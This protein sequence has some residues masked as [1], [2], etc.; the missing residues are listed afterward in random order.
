MVL[1][2]ARRGRNAGGQF[3][4]CSNYPNCKG[5]VPFEAAGTATPSAD[6]PNVSS[7]AKADQ[8]YFVP[9]QWSD[10]LVRSG[11]ISEYFSVGSVPYI[12]LQG[13]DHLTP[14]EERSL[15]QSV[16]LY[17]RSLLGAKISK[18]ALVVSNI[19]Q[20]ILRRGVCPTT[21]PR[22][23]ESALQD[24]GL[25]SETED[26]ALKKVEYGRYWKSGSKRIPAGLIIEGGLARSQFVPDSSIA[27]AS[28]GV[29]DSP[30]EDK[31]FNEWLPGIS[32][33]DARHWV[34]PQASL[35]LI[36][37]AFGGGETGFGG[38]RVDFLF[39]HPNGEHFV[40]E[41]D[42]EEHRDSAESDAERDR[43]LTAAGIDVFR[44]PNA[45]VQSG[46]G[47][48]LSRIRKR[49]EEALE[50]D[51]VFDAE[52][53]R[54]AS[55]IWECSFG[56][57]LQVAIAW[58]LQKGILQTGGVW[59]VR[60]YEHSS[61]S[62]D[63]IREVC[64]LI[65][66][67]GEI[68]GLDVAPTWIQIESDRG[69]TVFEKISH[70]YEE[71][72]RL[73][74]D[75]QSSTLSVRLE[76]TSSPL[77]QVR[78]EA[79]QEVDL[80]IRPAYFP[81]GLASPEFYRASRVRANGKDLP[82]LRKPLQGFLRTIFRKYEFRE[83][84]F[85]AVSNALL[86]TDSVVLLP[87]GAGKSIIYQL[88]GLLLPGV[89]LVVD[90]LV[91][92]IEDQ[93]DGMKLYGISKAIGVNAYT[94]K[95]A[96]REKV[97][98][99][100]GRGEYLFIL[101]APERLQD[102]QFRVTLA[103][104]AQISVINLAV[105]DEA[106]CVSEWGH[107]FRPSYL[108]LGR[109]LREFCKD[110]EGIPPP[111]VALTGTASR[112][113]LRDLLADLQISTEDSGALIRPMSFDRSEISFDIR[114]SK[115]GAAMGILGG[116]MNSIPND[117]GFPVGEFY[118]PS[119]ALT[120]SGIVFTKHVNGTFGLSTVSQSI[121]SS[122]P[123]EVTLYSGSAP[124]GYVAND[125][126]EVKRQNA[127]D[128]KSNKIPILVATKAFGM[129]IDKPN[130]RYTIHY[131]MP[132]SLE[133]FYQEAGRAG[134]DRNPAK[135]YVIY[136]EFDQEVTDSLLDPSKDVEEIRQIF[137]NL[138]RGS[139]DDASNSLW[140][141][142]NS[143][144][145]IET[146]LRSAAK[147]LSR[148]LPADQAEI[149]QIP[150]SIE[151]DKSAAEKAIFRLLQCG[152]LS[153][154]EVDNGSRVFGLYLKR[155]DREAIVSSVL[156]Y[157]ASSQ[158]GRLKDIAN[159]LYAINVDDQSGYVLQV[160]RIFITF[161]YDV[162]ERSRRRSL[163]ESMHA[164]REV[165]EETFRR[166]LLDY[167]QE[168][169]GAEAIQDLIVK[170][171]MEYR[172]WIGFLEKMGNAVE[173]G[174]VRGVAIRFLESYPDHPGL[175]LLRGIA[176]AKS[177]DP[178]ERIMS[179]SLIGSFEMAVERYSLSREDVEDAIGLL[180]PLIISGQLRAIAGAFS[181]AIY[182][183]NVENQDIQSF[184]QQ[185]RDLAGINP[186]AAKIYK[187][188]QVQQIETRANALANVLESQYEEFI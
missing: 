83:G 143:F 136:S 103:E 158:P 81:F 87:T 118:K 109:N 63:A 47:A 171:P 82:A 165:N 120:N 152:V 176:E 31:F 161:I 184:S 11:W 107:D 67:I 163:Q 170:D 144:Q 99:S 18:D 174:E 26:L 85:E 52:S 58:A 33:K 6:A 121:R 78:D 15:S 92:L 41:I 37:N 178:D 4:G 119:K 123:A 131:G 149:K 2:T 117:F 14:V 96:R 60:V 20:K 7:N 168:G 66:W 125:W 135:S 162:I 111:L 185:L 186:S 116:L 1:R 44:V 88:A 46:T 164:A 148:I 124:K 133:A 75:V 138:P 93:I 45:E 71:R 62:V 3:Y 159:R 64:E 10:A 72:E 91:S 104:L 140:F 172:D 177:S 106:H 59:R 182:S 89:T 38:R 74:E 145:G 55:L 30:L 130:I 126:E 134:R 50:K 36:G 70:E 80:V 157:I 151:E 188:L 181:L 13:G 169:I 113:V 17:R 16:F 5:I 95:G 141:H 68:Y 179:Q 32:S 56:S 22:L 166:R 156:A 21:T 43:I 42:G 39:A 105:I 79:G 49:I 115:P 65:S 77:E 110:S 122:A 127:S 102:P 154:Y 19:L 53:E 12:A 132:N 183:F 146:E 40:V 76:R 187:S 27:S 25:Y 167:L 128:F 29:F 137:E 129:G 86:G 173:A 139:R 24:V 150:F 73:P 84:Q 48:I 180:Y 94:L 155:F 97:L 51:V 98:S 175:L 90:P 8:S 28:G 114:R 101:L 142:L 108:H 160:L 61:T 147:I 69:N 100:V 54:V 153:D 34:T 35:E 23:E 57:K 9:I 112:A